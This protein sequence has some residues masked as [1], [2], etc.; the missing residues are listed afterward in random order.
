MKVE[1]LNLMKAIYSIQDIGRSHL[2]MLPSILVTEGLSINKSL[3]KNW[4]E[5]KKVYICI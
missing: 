5:Y 2:H 1:N 4:I 3:L